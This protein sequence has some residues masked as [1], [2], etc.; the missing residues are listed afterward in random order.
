MR[1]SSTGRA[2]PP[3]RGEGDRCRL[4]HGGRMPGQW[5]G[6]PLPPPAQLAVAR[7]VELARVQL[8]A[9]R[10]EPAHAHLALAYPVRVDGPKLAHV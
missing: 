2:A 4:H 1:T 9:A 5:P 8:T 6:R 3:A 10:V 7:C